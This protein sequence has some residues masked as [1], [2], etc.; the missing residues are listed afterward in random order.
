MPAEF[1]S[2]AVTRPIAFA[3]PSRV[4]G[5]SSRKALPYLGALLAYHSEIAEPTFTVKLVAPLICA[6]GAGSNVNVTVCMS[7]GGDVATSSTVK[8]L[9]VTSRICTLFASMVGAVSG[10]VTVAISS[11][12]PATDNVT[13]I[14]P[15][16]VPVC[17]GGRAT[18]VE[19]AGTL[20][21]VEVFVE[22]PQLASELKH[23]PGLTYEVESD[24]GIAVNFNDTVPETASELACASCIFGLIAWPAS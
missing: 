15:A 6:P 24:A 17:I 9:F 22:V 23:N 11:A 16:T 20:N 12:C 5:I 8:V 18:D 13:E 19:P 7:S 14:V 2:V 21:A 3:L 4:K 1:V 10:I